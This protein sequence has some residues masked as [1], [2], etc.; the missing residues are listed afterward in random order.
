MAQTSRLDPEQSR[1]DTNES[2]PTTP[3]RFRPPLT[4]SPAPAAWRIVLYIGYIGSESTR[5]VELDISAQLMVGRADLEDGYLPGLDLTSYDARDAG[6]SR[7]HATLF[8]TDGQVYLRDLNSTNGTRI[9]GIRLEPDHPCK[10]QA[11]DRIEFGHLP[12]MVQSIQPP[13]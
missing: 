2:A 3:L 13:A 8:A 12:V 7:R 6:V 10:V 9:N 1:S 5:A 11:G 4:F